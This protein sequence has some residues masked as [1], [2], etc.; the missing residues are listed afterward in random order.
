[1]EKN[2]AT[3]LSCGL[4]HKGKKYTKIVCCRGLENSELEQGSGG[5]NCCRYTMLVQKY[6]GFFLS[7]CILHL[8]GCSSEASPGKNRWSLLLLSC[9]PHATRSNEDRSPVLQV[10]PNPELRLNKWS[11]SKLYLNPIPL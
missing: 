9:G 1:M 4:F 8:L 10:S 3:N 7:Y 11:C 6:I 2:M 5:R